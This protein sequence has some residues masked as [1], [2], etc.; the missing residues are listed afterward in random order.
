MFFAI[1]YCY[2]KANNV[3]V[4]PEIDTGTGKIDFKFSKGFNSRVLVELK[5]STNTRL[6]HGYETQLETYKESEE[7]TK[8]I[9]VV[10]DV[11]KM[12]KKDENLIKLRNQKS[13][14]GLLL[15]DLIFVDGLIKP[16]ASKR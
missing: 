12:G 11:G 1:S 8:A 6:M 7:T 4:N 13:S 15:S 5:L 3:D 9:F 10:I 2:C 14:E 16:T